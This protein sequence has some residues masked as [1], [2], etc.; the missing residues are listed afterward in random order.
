[1]NSKGFEAVMS[2]ATGGKFYRLP[3][4]KESTECG[5]KRAIAKGGRLTILWSWKRHPMLQCLSPLYK[6]FRYQFRKQF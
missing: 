5:L 3:P 1:M 4:E 6:S 2:G